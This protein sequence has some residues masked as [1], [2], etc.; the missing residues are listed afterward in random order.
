MR[1]GLLSDTHDNLQGVEAAAA[2]FQSEGI[3]TLF[4]CGDVCGPAVV[5]ALSGFNVTFARGNMDRSNEL[6]LAV[7][8]HQGGRMARWHRLV[9]D[10]YQLALLHGDETD[11]QHQLTRSG[12]YAYIFCG[13]THYREDVRIGPTRLINPGALGGTRRESRSICILD[14]AKDTIRFVEFPF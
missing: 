2:V 10:G 5:E 12:E 7:E 3:D 9:L 11:L 13:H 4:H 1:I 6:A 8:T 14:L